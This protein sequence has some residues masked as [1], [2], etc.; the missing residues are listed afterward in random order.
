MAIQNLRIR[1]NQIQ[2]NDLIFVNA[3]HGNHVLKV[4]SFERIPRTNVVMRC[5]NLTTGHL[6]NMKYGWDARLFVER[7]D[8]LLERFFP[9]DESKPVPAP[10]RRESPDEWKSQAAG[11]DRSQVPRK[12][13]KAL[14][15]ALLSKPFPSLT[16]ERRVPVAVVMGAIT[17]AS[18]VYRQKVE[19]ILARS[20]WTEGE[21][22]EA[23]KAYL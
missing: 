9:H 23:M 11:A 17:K 3:K 12:A 14:P 15:E 6:G 22:S 13:P 20:G 16:P 8:E 19:E 21:L 1:A 10:R 7:Q 4:I 18:M 2:V 5:E